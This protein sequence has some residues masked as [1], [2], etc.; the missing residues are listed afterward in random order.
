M[1]KRNRVM[2]CLIAGV[3]VLAV[4]ATAAFGSVNGY[5]RYKEAV[6]ALALE[7]DNFSAVGS[8]EMTMDG[9]TVW[10][11]GA[12]IALDQEENS[13]ILTMNQGD[14]TEEE[15]SATVDGQHIWFDSSDDSTYRSYPAD[16]DEGPY[17]LLGYNGSDEYE[18]RLITFFEVACDTVVGELK[19]NFVQVGTE[20]GVDLYQVDIAQAQVPSLVNAGLSLFAYAMAQDSS[21][22]WSTTYEDMDAVIFHYYETQTGETLPQEFKDAYSGG[23]TDEWYQEN[24]ALMDKFESVCYGENS[25]WAE[26][27]DK[28]LED[29]GG[30][31]VYVYADG[32]YDYYSDQQSFLEA[33][34]EETSNN[35]EAYIGEDL[36]LEHIHCTFGVDSDGNLTENQI[37]VTF[38]TTGA[39]GSQHE[40]VISGEV[41]LSDFGATT[42]TMPDLTG[43][44]EVKV[45]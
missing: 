32:S 40:L 39:D 25:H 31:I 11:M 17:N 19:N 29:N 43:R 23:W 12:E 21:D 36:A 1:K 2:V 4:S 28:V 5:S 7:N 41:T 14:F 9:E 10:T 38:L 44:T 35:L 34:P 33:H 37:T 22:A 24:Q 30:G 26:A 16:P 42:V 18:S 3:L 45:G 20:D 13:T 15:V 27:Y 6:K 8:M